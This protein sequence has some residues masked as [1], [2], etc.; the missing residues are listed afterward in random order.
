MIN[1]FMEFTLNKR[2]SYAFAADEFSVG[3]RYPFKQIEIHESGMVSICCHAW[4]PKFCGNIITDTIDEIIEN[5]TR[6][7]ILHDMKQGKFTHCNDG[8]P[9][10][11]SYISTG[12]APIAPVAFLPLDVLSTRVLQDP[13]IINFS[14][15]RSCNLQCPSCRKGLIVY[16]L[17]DMSPQ[18]V[19]VRAIHDKVK[20]LVD[21]LV[22]RNEKVLLNITG[23]GDPFASPIYWQYL[24]ELAA[25]K[26]PDTFSI[27]L[28]T[29]GLLM[30]ESEWDDIKPLW[31]HITYVGVSVDAAS[32]DTYGI[33]RKNGNFDR[34]KKNLAYLNKLAKE[35]QFNPLFKWQTNMVVQTANYKELIEYTKWQ[36]TYESVDIVYFGLISHWGHL[37][38]EEFSSMSGLDGALLS[39]MLS[40]PVFADKRVRLGNLTNFRS[41]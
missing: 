17:D 40:D 2:E 19:T 29:N 16:K 41:G 12:K 33:I 5:A 32:K 30:T 36:L 11:G 39:S 14:Y 27:K 1:R 28:M 23:S 9:F 6:L 22:S 25:T 4:L 24:K 18:A 26:L 10:L 15:D 8:C 37:S 34:L 21:T 38:A 35:K 13:Y 3:C 7:S 31:K 20:L